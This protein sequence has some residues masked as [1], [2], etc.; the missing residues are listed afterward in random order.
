MRHPADV[1]VKLLLIALAGYAA[2]VAYV[3]LTQHRMIYLPGAA[4]GF[5]PLTPADLGLDYEDVSIPAPDGLRL[6]GW[7]VHAAGP[8]TVLF[9]HGNAG[10]ISHRLETI[11]FLNGLGAS[12][13]IVDY[14]G[15]GNSE[16][17]PSEQGTYEDAQAA[18]DYLTGER[19]VAPERIV[20]FGRSLGAPIAAWLASRQRPGGLVV[21]SAFT[22]VPELGQQ[23][24]PFLPVRWLSRFEYATR[25]LVSEVHCPVLVV[26]GRDDEIVPFTHA[27]AIYAAANAPRTLLELPGGHNDA[28]LRIEHGAYREGLQAFLGSLD[29]G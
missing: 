22:S 15:Y 21:E 7:L 10:N 18:W 5:G 8:L 1:I 13:L 14:R 20:V 16:G 27:E 29:D 24:Y 23:L 6:H 3:F 4:G 26:H 17:R 25:E 12:V 11:R 28:Y 2:L 9:F 19:G